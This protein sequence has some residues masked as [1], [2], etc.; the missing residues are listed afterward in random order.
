MVA[1]ELG[2]G[3]VISRKPSPAIFAETVWDPEKTREA[4]REIIDKAESKCHI[5]FIMKDIS[6]IRRNPKRLWEWSEI[7][8]DEVTK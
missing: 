6:S 5:E 2:S 1:V 4:I 3:Y 7:A 8:M